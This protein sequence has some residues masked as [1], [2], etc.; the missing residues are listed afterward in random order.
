M[1]LRLSRELTP[2]DVTPFVIRSPVPSPNMR[3]GLACG[4]EDCLTVF[5]HGYA[6]VSKNGG[7]L[8]LLLETGGVK[9]SVIPTDNGYAA[10]LASS[11]NG[12]WGPS[13]TPS[14]PLEANTFAQ[15]S[16]EGAVTG[17]FP[18]ASFSAH[19]SERTGSDLATNGSS[20]VIAGVDGHTKI[21]ASRRS[22]SSRFRRTSPMSRL[23]RGSMS[24]SG[25]S[26][27]I[28]RSSATLESSGPASDTFSSTRDPTKASL[29]ADHQRRRTSGECGS[30]PTAPAFPDLLSI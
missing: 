30:S 21:P 25:S 14:I 27:G 23:R 12:N 10:M 1:G 13:Q 26:T 20:I 5:D 28:N 2:L 7:V 11:R 19:L 29:I 6:L 17:P 9:N 15:F 24:T 4:S 18:L 3:I 8:S 16:E 22:M